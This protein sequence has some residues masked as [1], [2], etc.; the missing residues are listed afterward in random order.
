[1]NNKIYNE[2]LKY[3][4]EESLKKPIFFY[5]I[6]KCGGTTFADLLGIIFEKSVRITGTLFENNDKGGTTAFQNFNN[7][8]IKYLKK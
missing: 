7:N 3:E 2:C 8:K 4:T 6:P 5:H 1:M